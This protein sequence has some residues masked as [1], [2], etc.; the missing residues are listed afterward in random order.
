MRQ[1]AS[2]GTPCAVI[3]FPR[4]ARPQHRRQANPGFGSADFDAGFEFAM[5]LVRH[6]K[7]HGQLSQLKGV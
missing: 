7:A 2:S 6:L 5:S 1:S 3:P 4:S